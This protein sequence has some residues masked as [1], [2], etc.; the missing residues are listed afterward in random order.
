MLCRIFE[1]DSRVQ[2][3][4]A[5]TREGLERSTE[6]SGWSNL[7]YFDCDQK[8]LPKRMDASGNCLRCHWEVDLINKRVIVNKVGDCEHDLLKKIKMKINS[9]DR[10]IALE[11]ILELE[12]FKLRKEI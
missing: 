8:F 12:R 6:K 2:V 7:K 9:P 3:M 1:I 10:T 4:I 11:G 5:P